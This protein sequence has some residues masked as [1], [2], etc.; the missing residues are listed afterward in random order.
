MYKCAWS[1]NSVMCVYETTEH[2][3][4][5]LIIINLDSFSRMHVHVGCYDLKRPNSWTWPPT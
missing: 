4:K 3:H 5:L 2:Q 1:E